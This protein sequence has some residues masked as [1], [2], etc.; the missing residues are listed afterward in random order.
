MDNALPREKLIA[1][2][3][4]CSDVFRLVSSKT[5]ILATLSWPESITETFLR[6][7]A[8]VLPEPVYQVD[9]QGLQ[10]ALESL[11]TLK[12][13]IDGNHP[14]LEWLRRTYDSF[15]SGIRLLQAVE[16]P[17]FFKI[18]SELYGSSSSPV[19][20]GKTTMLDLATGVSGRM[21]ACSL[22]NLEERVAFRS[23]QEFAVELEKRLAARQPRLP[24]RV[25]V[26]PQISAKIAASASRIRIRE[27][28]EFS[29]IELDALWNHELESHCLTGQNGMAQKN[30][31]FLAGGGPRT[32]RTQEG[33]AV[34]Y[35]IFGHSMSQMRF[36]RLCNR[37]E[38]VHK[39][40]Q[41]ADFME[42]YR[43]FLP[44]SESPHEAFYD[45]Q[46]I[47]RGA[48]LTGRYPFT[49]DAVYLAGLL[50]VYQ[51]LQSSVRV[52]DRILVESL[53][54]GRIAL[55]DVGVIAWLRLHGI[56]DPPAYI[57][58]WL[59]NWDALLSFFSFFSVVLNSVDMSSFESY[60]D[61]HRDVH[62]WKVPM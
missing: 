59:S 41:G 9:H 49:K 10:D 8:N 25:E 2:L 1:L 32:T 23:A 47:F 20:R 29:L 45:T 11:H 40:E 60:L 33:L 4:E 12:G 57:P 7:N 56:I 51:F 48:P 24:V 61:A 13:K 5:K 37:I 53:V 52:Q 14:V 22:Q 62:D 50:E 15:E 27:N 28:A 18:S 34:F 38:A 17:G 36:I 3:K 44:R 30:V 42:L 21:V 39:V 35:E 19:G 6:N 43:W 46:R 16:T 54:A 26:T 31:P 58:G 55:E